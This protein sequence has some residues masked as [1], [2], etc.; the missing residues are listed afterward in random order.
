MMIESEKG[1][2]RIIATYAPVTSKVRARLANGWYIRKHTAN[3]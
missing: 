2:R 3:R 1:Q